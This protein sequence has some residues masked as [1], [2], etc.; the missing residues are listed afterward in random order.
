MIQD[1]HRP[2]FL[3]KPAQAPWILRERFGQDLDGHVTPQACI[4]CAIHFAHSSRADERDNFIR[5]QLCASFERHEFAEL[6]LHDSRRNLHSSHAS[7]LNFSCRTERLTR[8]MRGWSWAVR[9]PSS[10]DGM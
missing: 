6:Y 9:V 8:I 10:M 4:A 7:N 2:R 5:P 3:L 1:C